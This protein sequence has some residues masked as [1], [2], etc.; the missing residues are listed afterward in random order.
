MTKKKEYERPSSGNND[1]E[2]GGFQVKWNKKMFSYIGFICLL[3]MIFGSQSIVAHTKTDII[4][5]AERVETAKDLNIEKWS[6]FSREI[7]HEIT[8]K[9][10]FENWFLTISQS[11]PDFV[12]TEEY[13]KGEWKAVG[14]YINQH[15]MTETIKLSTSRKHSKM[16]SYL[17]Y[18][19]EGQEW[20]EEHASF[21]EKQFHERASKIFYEDPIIFSCIEGSINGSM[22]SALNEEMNKLLKTFEAKEI[23][24]VYEE[25]FSSVTAQSPLFSN[26][27]KN[28]EMN[29]Q[30]GV[31]IDGLGARTS[32][33]IGTPIIT[34]EY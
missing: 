6:V 10:D 25:N 14:S 32:F 4:S 7:N 19:V 1:E 8:T 5:L 27:L 29:V 24:S 18:E 20:E 2:G 12:W 28:T 26:T 17:V 3:V 21:F 34:F 33:V 16:I 13:D 30:F 11:F 22:D 15:S 31:R 9:L 23:E